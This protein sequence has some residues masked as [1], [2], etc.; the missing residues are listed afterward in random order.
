[1]PACAHRAW[2]LACLCRLP[3]PP[4]CAPPCPDGFT[5]SHYQ[6]I[7]PTEGGQPGCLVWARPW[8]SSAVQR[9]GQV[10]QAGARLPPMSSEPCVC[11]LR[12][13]R[14]LRVHC[15]QARLLRALPNRQ[16]RVRL[17]CAGEARPRGCNFNSACA[18]AGGVGTHL[19][20]CRTAAAGGAITAGATGY[21]G[22][23]RRL[24]SGTAACAPPSKG[25]CRPC[26]AHASQACCNRD[27]PS[28]HPTLFSFDANSAICIDFFGNQETIFSMQCSGRT[29]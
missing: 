20:A 27:C 19:A 17:V 13:R 15:S 23:L 29:Q 22:T 14:R 10:T 16:S 9:L 21:C 12:H 8:H 11:E 28:D 3:A 7:S 5:F 6:H 24:R 2:P 1:M 25:P 4:R 18:G 26:A